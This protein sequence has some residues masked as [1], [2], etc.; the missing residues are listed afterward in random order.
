MRPCGSGRTWRWCASPERTWAGT[1]APGASWPGNA[2]GCGEST[3]PRRLTARRAAGRFVFETENQFQNETRR[4]P[5]QA[6]SRRR[7]PGTARE[8]D[9]FAGTESDPAARPDRGHLLLPDRPPVGGRAGGEGQAAGPQHRGGH[10]VPDDE[11]PG[12]RRPRL[13]PALR[14]RADALRGRAGPAPPR[15][16]DLHLLRQHRRVRERAHRGAARP[17][18]GGP[19]FHRH[20]PQARAVRPLRRL[21][22]TAVPPKSQAVDVQES[23]PVMIRVLSLRLRI[24]IGLNLLLAGALLAPAARADRRTLIRAYEYMTQPKD[25]LELE[26]WNDVAAPKDGGFDQATTLHR[27]EL[28]Y[29][30]TDNWD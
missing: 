29:G 26:I 11:D 15:P 23:E 5:P 7:R 21:Q 4:H 8:L 20:P 10:R 6:C 25:N 12:R 2:A 19:R 3:S 28:E 17:G 16:P 24:T 27:V 1:P 13:R 22:A 9:R 18:G 14:R 30:V